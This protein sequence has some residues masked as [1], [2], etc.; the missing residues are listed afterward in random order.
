MANHNE[1][2][3]VTKCTVMVD[4]LAR[5][6]RPLNFSE[7]TVRT[8]FV[9][10]S[11][12]RILSILLGEQ[13]ATFDEGTRTYSLGPRSLIWARSY[14]KKSELSVIAGKHLEI[15]CQETGMNGT[16]SILDRGK[17]LNLS[18]FNPIPVKFATLVGDHAPLHCTAVGK[19]ILAYLP[20][21]KRSELLKNIEY[22]PYTNFTISDAASL[23][24]EVAKVRKRGVGFAMQEEFYQVRGIAA[25]VLIADN[26]A[27][28][29]ISMWTLTDRM[30]SEELFAVA[31]PLVATA[32]AISEEYQSAKM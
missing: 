2:S 15:L 17:A 11:A 9:K 12:H 22:E 8:G 19:V 10:S 4:I 31:D 1:S 23:E 27:L 29:A 28:A 30:S 13:L 6:E 24:K 16:M 18:S 32:R 5:S 7:L 21:D 25:P 26:T 14:L 20:E 3:I